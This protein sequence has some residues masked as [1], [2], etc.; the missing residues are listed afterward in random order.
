M[1]IVYPVNEPLMLRKARDARIMRMAYYLAARGR[2]VVLLVGRNGATRREILDY[3]G[4]N[5]LPNLEIVQIPI[6]RKNN[7]FGVSWNFVFYLFVLLYLIRRTR[8]ERVDVVYLSVLKLSRF[9]LF[10]RRW[11][12]TERFVYELHE[13]GIYPE[14]AR[15]NR[16]EIEVDRLEKKT[17]PRMDGVIVTTKMILEVLRKRF[18]DLSLAAIPLGTTREGLNLPPYLFTKK[19][20][21]NVCYIGQL[22][23]AQGVDILIR[24]CARIDS[25]HLHIIGGSEGE[26]AS[27][28]ALGR[29]LGAKERVSFHGFV[30]PNQ[31]I[32][33]I[34]EMDIMAL[35]ARESI[36]RRY[37]AFIKIYE[38]LSYGRPIVATSLPSTREDLIDGENAILVKP[39]DPDSFA[40]GIRKL[41][42]HPEIG[43]KI[44]AK[45]LEMAPSFFWEERVQKIE[46]FI[47]ALPAEKERPPE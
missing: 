12:R 36:R 11:I 2:R 9:L 15:P 14:N 37:V 28:Q 5:D 47:T 13:L 1:T 6:L 19:E 10:W 45:A 21:Y 16:S 46:R 34:P 35:P 32:K 30:S 24:A 17:L 39:D 33:V 44:A 23:S 31:I 25:V 4:I 22:F 40:E 20:R 27:L 7:P 26:I 41:I 29:E 3:Y 18:P 8:R 38:Y 43:R 42:H